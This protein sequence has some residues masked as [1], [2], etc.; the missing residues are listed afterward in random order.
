MAAADS[1]MLDV[2]LLEVGL[3]EVEVRGR[4]ETRA[5]AA[6]G[7]CCFTQRKGVVS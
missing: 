6:A 1:E 2:V 3:G 5:S 4:A 7:S